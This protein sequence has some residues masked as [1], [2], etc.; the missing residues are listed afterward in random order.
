MI[1][2]KNLELLQFDKIKSLVQQKCHSQQAKVLC[3]EISPKSDA[4]LILKELTQTSEVKSVIAGNGFFPGVE[5]DDISTEL[6]RLGL[7][8]A[9]LHESQ[10]LEV[11]KTV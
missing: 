10:L 9:L 11:L 3:S 8:G 4:A 5:H 1:E 6:G 2:K 7:N